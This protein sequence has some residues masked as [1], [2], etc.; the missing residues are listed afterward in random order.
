MAKPQTILKEQIWA[1]YHAA[2]RIA[3]EEVVDAVAKI[4]LEQQLEHNLIFGPSYL[5][6]QD[7]REIFRQRH[8]AVFEALEQTYEER[9]RVANAAAREKAKQEG[10][11]KRKAT[12]ARN[13]AVDFIRCAPKHSPSKI[14]CQSLTCRATLSPASCVNM[15]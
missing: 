13:K 7:F 5:V 8:P 6:T 9:N 2:H 14:S 12:L 10:I 1:S 11:A 3:L 4:P 15:T